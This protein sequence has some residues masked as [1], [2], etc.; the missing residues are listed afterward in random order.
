VRLS[1]ASPRA[2][3]RLLSPGRRHF[4]INRFTSSSPSAA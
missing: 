1:P 2:M 4:G 3:P